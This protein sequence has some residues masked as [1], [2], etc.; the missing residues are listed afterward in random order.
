[1]RYFSVSGLLWDTPVPEASKI[2]RESTTAQRSK[3]PEGRKST[4]ST[5]VTQA[6]VST[7]NNVSA[8]ELKVEPLATRSRYSEP[9]RSLSH[10]PKFEPNLAVLQ[11][12]PV[13]EINDAFILSNSK[14]G[15]IEKENKLI[16]NSKCLSSIENEETKSVK[17]VQMKNQTLISFCSEAEEDIKSIKSEVFFD[18]EEELSQLKTT[19]NEIES[20]PLQIKISRRCGRDESSVPVPVLRTEIHNE[21]TDEPDTVSKKKNS[22]RTVSFSKASRRWSQLRSVNKSNS[23]FSRISRKL[24]IFD[25]KDGSEDEVELRR[26]G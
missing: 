2:R 21:E 18:A 3:R 23:R 15:L 19:E 8:L 7:T 4:S 26:K 17:S 9:L 5:L 6:I 12:T 25:A 20:K 22:R 14:S 11:E 1:M 24:S 10:V 16:S 13:D